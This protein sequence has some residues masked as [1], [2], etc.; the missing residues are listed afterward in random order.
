MVSI[1]TPTA[2]SDKSNA[3]H[4]G[5]GQGVS[6]HAPY[7]GSDKGARNYE[8]CN[9]RFNPRPLCRERPAKA[10]EPVETEEFQ[11]TP[12]MQGATKSATNLINSTSKF[13]STPPMQGATS[14]V[15]SS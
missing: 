6:I 7:A 5:D 14:F 11:S 13:Q 4:P 1:H 8:H 12:P 3:G 2:G 15:L 10:E 9:G